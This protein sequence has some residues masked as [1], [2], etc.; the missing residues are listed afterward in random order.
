MDVNVLYIS[1][2]G[3][4][5]AL[6]Q[7]QVLPYL[8]GISREGYKIHLISFE[9]EV[10]FQ[11]LGDYIHNV[12]SE[13]NIS[14]YPQKYTKNPPVFSTVWDIYKM[15]RLAKKLHRKHNFKIVHCRSYTSSIIGLKLQQKY[16]V[17]FLFDMR[18]F[19][20]D[21]RVDGGQWD[22]SKFLYK[23]IY[24]YFKKK[25]F[26]LFSS[27]DQCVSL[28]EN[29]KTELLSW[30]L[31]RKNELPVNVI[32]CCADLSHF[33]YK[34]ITPEIKEIYRKKYNVQE[35]DLAVCYLGSLSTVYMFDQV[36]NV[37]AELEKKYS[38]LKFL[39]FTHEDI[40]LVNK[41][42]SESPVKHTK[43]ITIDSLTR[44]DVPN[45]LSICDYSIFFCKPTYSRKGTSPTR[46]AELIACGVKV[47]SNTNIGDT[48]THIKENNLGYV[49]NGFETEDIQQFVTKFD[50]SKDFPKDNLHQ[51]AE[52]LF[53]LNEGV[54]KYLAI[55]KKLL[56]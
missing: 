42:I 5:D 36:L 4:T 12:C 56:S 51:T 46:L 28:T 24:S 55:Y 23:N 11:H 40:T 27:C 21:E 2:D 50:L 45:A 39:V 16:G 32:P 17:K 1:Y 15:G 20:V 53:S 35:N 29:G 47:I 26:E 37:I 7:S 13:S 54:K 48:E 18:G 34:R 14:W 31:N 49:F 43:N 3:M 44:N 10:N 52:K 9:K 6:G 8:F 25:E 22:L 33:D 41:Y 38:N 30:K 19:W